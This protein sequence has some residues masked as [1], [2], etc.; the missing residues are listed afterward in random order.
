VTHEEERS[1]PNPPAPTPKHPTPT[2]DDVENATEE[3]TRDAADN[4]SN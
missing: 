4:P 2:A 1:T 3:A